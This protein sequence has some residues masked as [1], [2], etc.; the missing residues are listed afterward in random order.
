MRRRLTTAALVG[1]CLAAAWPAG[2]SACGELRHAHAHGRVGRVGRAPLLV[3]D[4]TSIIAAPVLGRLGVE[5]DAHGC[6]QFGQGLQMLR[7]RRHAHTLPHVVALALGANG[8]VSGGQ[9][10]AAL[11]IMGP[12]RVLALVTARRSGFTDAAMHR[13]AHRYPERVLLIDWVR[14]SAGHGGWF[15]GDG[16]H[17]GRE[18]ADAYAHLIL[19]R[20]APFAFPPVRKLRVG[21]PEAGKR[22]GVVHR[23]GRALRVFVPRGAER[24]R[25]VRARAIVKIPPMRRIAGWRT[26]DWRASRSRTWS[27]VYARADR[28]VLVGAAPG[29]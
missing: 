29:R 2:A 14:F 4:S 22:C 19:R 9:I 16:L 12:S 27:W 21:R 13:S 6:R 24:I 10:S 3:G 7:A 1:V 5:A 17:V 28:S 18:G 20:I 25:C 26:Y 15:A 11:R 8:P 23:G